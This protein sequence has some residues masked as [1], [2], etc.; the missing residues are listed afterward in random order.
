MDFS[1]KP[2]TL[3]GQKPVC[4]ASV[5]ASIRKSRPTYVCFRFTQDILKATG[6]K[7]GTV[8]TLFTDEAN[9][10]IL[11]LSDQRPVPDGSR[12]LTNKKGTVDIEFPNEGIFLEWFG[13]KP[14]PQ[15]PMRLIEAKPGR[16]VF[17]I[18]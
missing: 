8:L 1:F 10:A 12:K 15:R 9:K 2:T 6:W 18:P 5:A 16:L 3:L 7:S 14:F 11:L 17:Q 13:S 4:H